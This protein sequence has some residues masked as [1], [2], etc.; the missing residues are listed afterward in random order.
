MS[1]IESAPSHI[2]A[3]RLMAV[4]SAFA[5][6]FVGTLTCAATSDGRRADSASAMNGKKPADAIRFGSCRR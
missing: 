5:P 4:R 1:W 6:L 2:R 3:T